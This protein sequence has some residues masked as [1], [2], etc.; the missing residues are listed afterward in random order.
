MQYEEAT[1]LRP[2]MWKAWWLWGTLFC[3]QAEYYNGA[4]V[5]VI[6]QF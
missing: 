2:L 3:R 6:D 5:A 4:A 1:R